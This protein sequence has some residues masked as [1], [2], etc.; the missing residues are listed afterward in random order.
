[1]KYKLFFLS[2][3]LA[4]IVCAQTPELRIPA[5]HDCEEYAFNKDDQMMATLGQSEV[6]IW[7]VTGGYLLKTLRWKGIDTL[8][9]QRLLFTPDNQRLLVYGSR[10]LRMVNLRTLEWENAQYSIPEAD[11]MVI[12]PDSKTLYILCFRAPGGDN[13][14]KIDLATGKATIIGKTSLQDGNG[15]IDVDAGGS[16]SMNAAGTLLLAEG[17]SSGGLVIDVSNAKILKAFKGPRPC[18]FTK[19]NNIVTYT[20][21]DQDP[22]VPDPIFKYKIEEIEYGTWKTLRTQKFT[23]DVTDIPDAM[24]IVWHS[25]DNRGRILFECSNAFWLFDA[26]T[27]KVSERRTYTEGYIGGSTSMVYISSSGKYFFSNQSMQMFSCE[28]GQLYK[29][30]GF[31]VFEPFNLAHGSTTKTKGIMAGY[32][33]M[34]LDPNGFRLERLPGDRGYDHIQ[35]DIYR[36]QPEQ[37]NLLMTNSMNMYSFLHTSLKDPERK[38]EDVAFEDAERGIFC[39]EMRSYED[40][41]TI[42]VAD[43]S[44]L[45]LIDDRTWTETKNVAFEDEYRF[46]HFY[47]RD[48]N[49]I[50]DRSPDKTRIIA[51]LMSDADGAEAHRIACLDY[52]TLEMLWYHDEQGPLSNPVWMDGGQQVWV[53][54]SEGSIRKLDGK[55]GKLLS[56]TNKIPYAD[57]G[58]SFS[59]SGKMMVNTIAGDE[60]VYGVTQLNVLDANTLQLKYALKQQ[61][62]PYFGFLF[63]D[64][65][66][67]LITSDEDVKV[68]NAATGKLLARIVV[69]EKSQDWIVATPDGRFDGS[70]DGLK[71]MYYMKGREYIP[72]EQLYESFYTPNL[73]YEVMYGTGGQTAAPVEF[74]QLKLPPTVRIVNQNT[75]LRNL[76]VADNDAPAYETAAKTVRLMVEAD[77]KDDKI[78]EIKL[79]HNGKLLSDGTRGFKPVTEGGSISVRDFEVVLLPG[80]NQF[81]AVALNTQR[82][83]ST[84]GDIFIRYT[85]A[86]EEKKADDGIT[87]HLLVIGINQYKNT[88]HNL[89]YAEADALAFK[90]ELGRNCGTVVKTC[91]DYYIT[92]D[93]A[94]K[95]TIEQALEQI[96]VNAKP[97]DLFV[98]Y[99]AG[100]GVMTEKREFFLVPHDV[101][102]I[103]GNEGGLA[104]RGISADALKAYSTKIKAQKQLFILDACHSSGALEAVASF[105]GAA[106]EKAISQLARSTGTHWLTA[107]GSEQYAAEFTQLG[108]GVFT[109]ALLEA[110]KGAADRNGDGKITI[111]E[112]DA[113][114]QDEVPVLTEKYKGTAQYPSSY[115]FGQD[116]PLGVTRK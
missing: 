107:A 13:L 75:G 41:H 76:V 73:L 33:H 98:L 5:A 92:N 91:K 93:K 68:W 31:F 6:K 89:N 116:F 63:F 16:A 101:T 50:L 84:P 95:E 72:L 87:M 86:P 70:P 4:N 21:I 115:N 109:Y 11:N 65:D 53:V 90:D 28:T 12:S 56:K 2:L 36:L 113:Y 66:R 97:Q 51:H 29:K 114:L 111:K 45:R 27:W 103:Y 40:D 23:L 104:Q 80:E 35:R 38:I 24:G 10:K 49:Y 62:I 34:V 60:S 54:D 67:F 42:L 32:Q 83:E 44:I 110:M 55:T 47:R 106:E 100:H 112:V 61:R 99:Y 39:T 78:A 105:R 1:M 82:T 102:Q 79:F 64:N 43:E 9:N 18:F 15:D 108:H 57:A 46:A 58:S 8:Y 52:K 59:K 7:D 48:E 77:G 96:S 30:I 74:N 22:E 88:K 26:D 17:Y 20:Q 19:N 85:P 71:S 81:R 14:Q 37:Q 69:I 3:L 94:V 25:D